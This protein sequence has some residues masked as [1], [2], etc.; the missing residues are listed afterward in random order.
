MKDGGTKKN[1]IRI[2][3]WLVYAACTVATALVVSTMTVV[4][5]ASCFRAEAKTNEPTV[6]ETLLSDGT[7]NPWTQADLVAA[8]GLLNRRYHRDIETE[9]GRIAWHGKVVRREVVTNDMNIIMRNTYEDGFTH[10]EEGRSPRPVTPKV[11]TIP[12]YMT[13]NVPARLAVARVAAFRNVETVTT[14]I[15]VT[16]GDTLTKPRRV[17]QYDDYGVA[18][19]VSTDGTIER[20]FTPSGV[21]TRI[22]ESNGKVSVQKFVPGTN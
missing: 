3:N 17:M 13:N 12:A 16:V 10:D 6:V 1:I 8:L 21:V 15:I 22:I 19:N 2:V 9:K 7:T 14:N 18:T 11:R 4:L 20:E 5:I